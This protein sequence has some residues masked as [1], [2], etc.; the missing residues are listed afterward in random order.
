MFWFDVDDEYIKNYFFSLPFIL[1]TWR[2]HY[3]KIWI[4]IKSDSQLRFG[5]WNYNVID[6]SSIMHSF[7][8][9][10]WH[11]HWMRGFSQY[12]TLTLITYLDNFIQNN[13]HVHISVE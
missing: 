6:R 11:S 2:N 7:Q 9:Q 8:L 1:E 3:M 13:S 10:N 5:T 12:K 4:L